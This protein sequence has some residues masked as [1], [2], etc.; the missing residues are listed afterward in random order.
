MVRIKPKKEEKLNKKNLI[1]VREETKKAKEEEKREVKEEEKTKE[2]IEEEIEK[3]VI[4]EETKITLKVEI[5]KKPR[6]LRDLKSQR[7]NPSTFSTETLSLSK[8]SSQLSP[9]NL[10]NS[11]DHNTKISNKNSNPLNLKSRISRKIEINPSKISETK[12][13]KSSKKLSRE[14]KNSNHSRNRSSSSK[15]RL[16]NS[17]KSLM[18]SEPT[19]LRSTPN[20][21]RPRMNTKPSNKK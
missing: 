15:T 14:E 11:R 8:L 21:T 3:E 10:N 1:E 19:I 18:N 12:K 16:M 2:K 4:E 20:S 6:E 13:N 7:E 5:T 9:R 17:K